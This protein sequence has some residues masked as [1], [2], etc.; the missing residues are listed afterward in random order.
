MYCLKNHKLPIEFSNLTPNITDS[1][2]VHYQPNPILVSLLMAAQLQSQCAKPLT[3]CRLLLKDLSKFISKV[4]QQHRRSQ[5]IYTILSIQAWSWIIAC[6]VMSAMSGGTF[7]GVW[8]QT[9]QWWLHQQAL[10]LHGDWH[11]PNLK[12]TDINHN[13][14][15]KGSGKSLNI[16]RDLRYLVL[17]HD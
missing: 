15:T 14:I 16:K 13:K 1:W 7:K 9:A 3:L 5:P 10:K 8:V 12:S 2:A 17:P 4:V 11:L 6:Y